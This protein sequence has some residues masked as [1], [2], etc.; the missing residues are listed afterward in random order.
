MLNNV[1][2]G[3][4]YRDIIYNVRLDKF[5]TYEVGDQFQ[6]LDIE[7]G[8]GTPQVPSGGTDDKPSDPV[9]GNLYWDTDLEI[10]LIYNGTEWVPI[11]KD[12]EAILDRHHPGRPRQRF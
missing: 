12:T 7:T 2:K 4:G 8:G 3:L 10:L 11:E 9:E 1:K 5:F 6:E